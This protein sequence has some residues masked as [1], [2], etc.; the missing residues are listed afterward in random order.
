MVI[1][2]YDLFFAR[3]EKDKKE[4]GAS[5]S[6]KTN[7]TVPF[8][9]F[10]DFSR[11]INADFSDILTIVEGY[12]QIALRKLHEGRLTEEHLQH[13]L[14]TLRRGT[15]LT[16]E[17]AV[18]LA[19]LPETEE[20]CDLVQAV[21]FFEE[22]QEKDTEGGAHL[23]FPEEPCIIQGSLERIAH[24]IAVLLP[25]VY[26]AEGKLSDIS[27]SLEKRVLQDGREQ[28]VLNMLCVD[29]EAEGLD[30]MDTKLFYPGAMQ[31]K[32]REDCLTRLYMAYVLVDR[33]GGCVCTAPGQGAHGGQRFQLLFPVVAPSD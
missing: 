2:P 14:K 10:D 13:I 7:A 6:G 21:R 15:G 27:L 16:E 4:E 12:T 25:Y 17:I 26:G 22:P 1:R 24:V 31:I 11:H 33:M 18:F 9:L 28:A 29:D 20:K 23:S 3:S 32:G 5:E 19:H 30:N 8:A